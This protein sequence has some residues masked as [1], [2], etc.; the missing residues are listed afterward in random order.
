MPSFVAANIQ[1]TFSVTNQSLA[2]CLLTVTVPSDGNMSFSLWQLALTKSIVAVRSMEGVFGWSLPAP[3]NAAR[4]ERSVDSAQALAVCAKQVDWPTAIV[5]DAVKCGSNF[6]RSMALSDERLLVGDCVGIVSAIALDFCTAAGDDV[7]P[8]GDV[9]VV[10][11]NNAPSLVVKYETHM[12]ELGN[13]AA[14]MHRVTAALNYEGAIMCMWIN[15]ENRTAIV[16]N[17]AGVLCEL[18]FELN[19]IGFSFQIVFFLF[20]SSS[21]LTCSYVTF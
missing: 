19:E 2:V 11:I 6:F 12:R 16:C 4:I 21:F 7:V 5:P 17:Q 8:W 14:G 3:F 13:D 20:F 18:R 9:M 10:Q 1:S 15:D